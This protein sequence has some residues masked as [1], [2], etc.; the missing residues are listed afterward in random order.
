M[1]R[2]AK[3]WHVVEQIREKDSR[4][5]PEA[6]GLVMEALDFTM[7]R[8]GERR[9]ISAAELLR[10]VCDHAKERYGLL[11]WTVIESWGITSGRDVG[12][13]VYQLIEVGV[14]ARQD[15]DRFEDFGA[16]WDFKEILEHRYFD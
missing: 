12:T 2:D 5:K 9:H 14:L 10:G 15:S 11:A 16:D 8:L 7:R 3:F 4:Y 6:Y 1:G 13:I